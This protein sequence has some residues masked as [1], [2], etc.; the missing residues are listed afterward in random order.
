[1]S[2]TVPLLFVTGALVMIQ[3]AYRSN[4]VCDDGSSTLFVEIARILERSLVNNSRLQIT[5]ALTVSNGR[6]V[7][8]LEGPRVN[9]DALFARVATDP[10]HA[11]VRVVARRD[12]DARSFAAWSMAYVGRGDGNRIM[13]MIAEGCPSEAAYRA[14]VEQVASCV[15]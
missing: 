1:M 6:F 10:R 15:C 5:G 8:I 9:V 11:D 14:A 13:E 2:V 12:I 7:Q 4:C 3:L